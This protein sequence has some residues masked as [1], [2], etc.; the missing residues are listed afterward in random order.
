MAKKVDFAWCVPSKELT[1]AGENEENFH[2]TPLQKVLTI[3]LNE[4]Y[5]LHF[6][7]RWKLNCCNVTQFDSLMLFSLDRDCHVSSSWNTNYICNLTVLLVHTVT[8]GPYFFFLF[9]RV[10]WQLLLSFELVES[11]NSQ[12][13]GTYE[14]SSESYYINYFSLI[15]TC[16]SSLIWHPSCFFATLLACWENL[17][18]W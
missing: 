18:N 8:S 9:W 11:W 4:L 6:L 17:A 5:I 16:F 3:T 10:H 15:L 2:R 13:T 7:H 14:S 12:I 1:T